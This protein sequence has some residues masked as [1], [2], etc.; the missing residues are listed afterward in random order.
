MLTFVWN[1]WHGSLFHRTLA[2]LAKRN[3]RSE[4]RERSDDDIGA[5]NDEESRDEDGDR[6]EDE[7]SDSNEEDGITGRLGVPPRRTHIVSRYFQLTKRLEQCVQN[8][9]HIAAPLTQSKDFDPDQAPSLLTDAV[10]AISQSPIQRH[11]GGSPFD[12]QCYNM[13]RRCQ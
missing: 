5:D 7:Y 8:F 3:K 2:E 10:I 4:G 6:T 9:A 11:M 1:G 13:L 12:S